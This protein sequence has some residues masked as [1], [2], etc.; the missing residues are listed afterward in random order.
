LWLHGIPGARKTVLAS[1]IFQRV[2]A[3]AQNRAPE[4]PG[5]AYYY[6][7]F[8][9]GQEESPHFL[10]WI[11]SQLCRQINQI[12]P[13]VSHIFLNGGQPSTSQ[14]LDVLAAVVRNFPCIYMVIDA[15][16][17]SSEREKITKLLPKIREDERFARLQI[18]ATS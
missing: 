9:R 3:F 1:Y 16:D 7:Y 5:Y 8:S 13:K 2:E 18:L 17:E 14:L 15:L 12:P 4:V 10:R 11:I 6:Y